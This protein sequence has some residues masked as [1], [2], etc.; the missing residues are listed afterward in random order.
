MRDPPPSVSAPGSYVPGLHGTLPSILAIATSETDAPPKSGGLGYV[1]NQGIES[2][3]Q[4]LRSFLRGI[5]LCLTKHD[6]MAGNRGIPLYRF[7]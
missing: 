1:A 4:S 7:G 2:N 3:A 6:G 5:F